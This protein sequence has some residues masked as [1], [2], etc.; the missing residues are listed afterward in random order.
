MLIEYSGS[1]CSTSHSRC[2]AKD[3]GEEILSLF[4]EIVGR[5]GDKFSRTSPL[6]SAIVG[7]RN[8]AV[9]GSSQRSRSRIRSMT[10]APLKESPPALK[11][12]SCMPMGD[13]VPKASANIAANDVSKVVRGAA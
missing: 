11:K 2:C 3:S 1:S 13:S 12:L 8:K 6:N 5:C 10:R 7:K 4:R 9:M